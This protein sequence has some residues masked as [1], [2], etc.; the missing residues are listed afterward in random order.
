MAKKADLIYIYSLGVIILSTGLL[1]WFPLLFFY[2]LMS[3]SIWWSEEMEEACWVCWFFNCKHHI[4]SSYS[5]RWS[6]ALTSVLLCLD[7]SFVRKSEIVKKNV[8]CSEENAT[9][10]FRPSILYMVGHTER[11]TFTTVDLYRVF[12]TKCTRETGIPP[13]LKPKN[14]F[15]YQKY[16]CY[17]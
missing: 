13:V 12:C 6:A 17:H 2:F 5:G 7:S 8:P 9:I 15:G 11:S 10:F 3:C 16:Y 4:E 14:I 1:K